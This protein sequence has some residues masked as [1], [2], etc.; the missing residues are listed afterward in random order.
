MEPFKLMRILEKLPDNF[1]QEVF[2]PR[3][4]EE[5]KPQ[6]TVGE[7]LKREFSNFQEV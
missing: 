3:F 1:M 2:W 5:A 7:F 6:E 4:Q